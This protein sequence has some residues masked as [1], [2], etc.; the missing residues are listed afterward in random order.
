MASKSPIELEPVLRTFDVDA[1]GAERSAGG[2]SFAMSGKGSQEPPADA[3]K[4]FEG[5]QDEAPV[6]DTGFAAQSALGGLFISSQVQ[7]GPHATFRSFGGDYYGGMVTLNLAGRPTMSSPFAQHP[8]V[9][10]CVDRI[11]TTFGALPIRLERQILQEGKPRWVP[12]S[13]YGDAGKSSR[14]GSAAPKRSQAG[15]TIKATAKEQKL[16]DL[17]NSPN[18]VLSGMAF[19][20]KIVQHYLLDGES[21]LLFMAQ[22]R[23]G[24]KGARAMTE[25][26][27]MGAEID[28][29]DWIWPVRGNHMTPMTA[30][31][32]GALPSTYQINTGEDWPAGSAALII[33]V[34]P[35][36]AVRGMGPLS[37]IRRKLEQDFT[38][39][40]FTDAI[41]KNGGQPSGFL[42]IKEQIDRPKKKAIQESYQESVGGSHNAGKIA[43]L[44]AGAEFKPTGLKPQEMQFGELLDRN[45]KWE[46]AVLGTTKV[47]LGITE[48][49]NRATAREEMRGWY[50]ITIMP[51]A[52]VIE[53][54]LNHGLVNRIKGMRS[55]AKALGHRIRFDFSG[56]SV[57]KEDVQSKAEMAIK[58][59][60]AYGLSLE[61][62]ARVVEW[63]ASLDD[64]E[65]AGERWISNKLRPHEVATD[66]EKYPD[67]LPNPT[68]AAEPS[69]KSIDTKEDGPSED[70]IAQAAAEVERV[71]TMAWKAFDGFLA[72]RE[73]PTAKAAQKVLK[74]YVLAARKRLR[75]IANG[76]RAAESKVAKRV[77]ARRKTKGE[78]E[79]A[80][81]Y[82]ANQAEIQRALALNKAEW[83][84]MM[85]AEVFPELKKT[86][87]EAAQA[88][89]LEVSGGSVVVE[90][91]DP[92]VL[93][94]LSEK[95]IS[96]VEGATSTLAKDVQA[97][98]VKVLA[99]AEEASSLSA[100]V[101]EVLEKLEADM[102]TMA[103]QMGARAEMI[104]RTET[105]SATS[106][107]RTEQMGIDGIDKHEWLSSRDGAVRDHHADL[108]GKTVA[109]GKSFGF[110]LHYPGDGS[111]GADPGDIINCRCTTLPV[112]E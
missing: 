3:L 105:A 78:P 72:K 96:L 98:I 20:T 53:D 36:S 16:I 85:L 23:E 15:E 25:S 59:S 54:Q 103:G 51:M 5:W 69:V 37:P 60:E 34:S 108:E 48:N 14:A 84:A 29:P 79:T 89:N 106:F 22:G 93:K 86:I 40:R 26:K 38:I 74:S 13:Q 17:L 87:L 68:R 61:D 80:L 90:L 12:V 56:V 67:A 82:V 71:K 45:E 32:V 95:E 99:G 94:F 57:L 4:G 7:V 66:P 81:K 62:A 70:E 2:Y 65:G 21:L 47:V 75:E 58:L 8:V 41:L 100:A 91:T 92:A 104:A 43:V 83:E 44:D 110:N 64:I 111:H 35:D 46:M 73:K 31:G 24:D 88:L 102:T 28:V 63:S 1:L 33:K 55:E 107:A 10:A 101:R 112:V 30:T 11:A 52:R 97:K 42:Y 18:P 9:F 50:E 49:S 109:V 27:F 77:E 6:G 39:D 76:E 19:R